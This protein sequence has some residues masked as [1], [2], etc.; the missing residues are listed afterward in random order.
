[1]GGNDEEAQVLRESF[2]DL[3]AAIPHDVPGRTVLDWRI[4]AKQ[5]QSRLLSIATFHLDDAR[6]TQAK[7]RAFM[8]SQSCSSLLLG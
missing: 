2:V 6:R 8:L 1:M 4:R 5:D 3:L 7:S